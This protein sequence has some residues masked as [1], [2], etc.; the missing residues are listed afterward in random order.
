MAC[1]TISE[2]HPELWHPTV[3]RAATTHPGFLNF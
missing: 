1:G 2:S 3:A